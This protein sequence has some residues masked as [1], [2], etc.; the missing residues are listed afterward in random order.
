MSRSIVWVVVAIIIV[1]TG[2]TILLSIGNLSIK[3]LDIGTFIVLSTT[4]VALVFYAADTNRQTRIAQSKWERDSLLSATYGMGAQTDRGHPEITSFALNNPTTMLVRAKIWADCKVYDVK[5]NPPDAY[6]GTE[7]WVLFPQQ[8][9][10]GWFSI[11]DLLAQQGKTMDQMRS[12]CV[13]QNA[14]TQLTLDLTIE[15]RDERRSV[16]KLPTRTHY[17]SFKDSTW[18]PVLTRKDDKLWENG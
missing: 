12:E 4:L 14:T 1:G 8:L 6:N 18:I 7:T 5:V 15:F 3:P 16:R 17:Y 10:Q 11:A 13:P 2:L 9:S